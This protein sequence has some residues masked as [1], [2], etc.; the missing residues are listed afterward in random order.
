MS[1]PP[2]KRGEP[3]PP[4]TLDPIL[5]GEQIDYLSTGGRPTLLYFWATWCRECLVIAPQLKS[6]AQKHDIQVLA[7]TTEDPH[8]VRAVNSS[9]PLPFTLLHDR[10][11]E[12]TR[13]FRADLQAKRAPVFIYL[14]VERRYIERGVGMGQHGPKNIEVLFDGLH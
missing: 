5:K 13:L 10:G 3:I 8:L 14:D 1:P 11:R 12:A 2:P 4:L 9:S 6:W 7:I